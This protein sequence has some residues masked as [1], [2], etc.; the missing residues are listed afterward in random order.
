MFG[1]YTQS[2]SLLPSGYQEALLRPGENYAA[3]IQQATGAMA[4]AIVKYQD[5]RERDAVVRGKSEAVLAT[6]DDKWLASQSQDLQKLVKKFGEGKE[7]HDD[8]LKLGSYLE[9]VETLDYRKREDTLKDLQIKQAQQQDA[10]NAAVRA[11]TAAGLAAPG[12]S[13]T[14]EVRAPISPEQA[15]AEIGRYYSGESEAAPSPG[16]DISA[17]T[18]YNSK[19]AAFK[20]EQAA[21]PSFQDSP[22]FA[23]DNLAYEQQRAEVE[24]T[25]LRYSEDLKSASQ[26]NGSRTPVRT[27]PPLVGGDFGSDFR[28]EAYT[29]SPLEAASRYALVDSARKEART[30]IADAKAKLAALKAPEKLVPVKKT[31]TLPETPELSAVVGE[32]TVQTPATPAQQF[33]V[34]LKS[35]AS[36]GNASPQVIAALRGAFGAT[37]VKVESTGGLTLVTEGGKV[38]QAF[39]NKSATDDLKPMTSEEVSKLNAHIAASDDIANLEAALKKQLVGPIVGIVRGSNAWDTSAKKI[40]A[41]VN[42][43]V[44]NIARGVFG[45]VGVLTDRDVE[46]YAGMLPNLKNTEEQSSAL[47]GI[48]RDKLSRSLTTNITGLMKANRDVGRWAEHIDPKHVTAGGAGGG[49]NY[50]RVNG[51]LVKQ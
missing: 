46:R 40:N 34:A 39:Q 42:A 4:G 38:V 48:L 2:G 45:E 22:T 10:D 17:L 19:L 32:T 31:L 16:V 33:G 15:N 21:P 36:S 25:L 9:A 29:E 20:A 3:G 41:M 43:S 27:L 7:S 30:G 13:Y 37:D 11:A 14:Q 5:M 44:P 35:L 24:K 23:A 8:L 28:Q 18:N 26:R 50:I 47:L 49:A 1:R 6:K 12:S 51:K